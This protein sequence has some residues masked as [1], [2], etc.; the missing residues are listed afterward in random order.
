MERVGFLKKAEDFD[1]ATIHDISLEG[2]LVVVNAD[3]NH[4]V[5]D[6]VPIRFQGLDGTVTVKHIH[7]TDDG[8]TTFGVHFKSDPEF[9]HAIDLAVGRLRGRSAELAWE[10]QN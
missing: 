5:G 7:R 3:R 4:E 6:V 10:R 1:A 9:R 8:K 2:A